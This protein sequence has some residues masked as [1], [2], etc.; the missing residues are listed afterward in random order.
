MS[1]WIMP[2]LKNLTDE[3]LVE[4]RAGLDAE[5]SH[6]VRWQERK[7]GEEEMAGGAS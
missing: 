5:M 1:E 6:R 7:F 2:L 3:E 4:L